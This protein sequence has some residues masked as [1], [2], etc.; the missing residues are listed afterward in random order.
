MNR[1]SLRNNQLKSLSVECILD[2]FRKPE[3]CQHVNRLDLETLGILT[4][5]AQKS[6]VDT[7]TALYNT[8]A[9]AMH[10]SWEN[11]S[12][13]TYRLKFAIL[14]GQVRWMCSKVR[15][16]DVHIHNFGCWVRLV[17]A[18][19]SYPLQILNRH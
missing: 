8:F 7:G 16:R 10:E 5:Y 17:I 9:D 11:L 12:F 1:L 14:H 3:R 15:D 13:R 2:E 18:S 19:S 6:P 4:D